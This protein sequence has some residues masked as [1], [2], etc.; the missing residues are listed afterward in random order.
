MGVNSPTK[1][2]FVGKGLMLKSIQSFDLGK[3]MDVDDNALAFRFI[4]KGNKNLGE[5][6][7][8]MAFHLKHL[9]YS[10][11]FIVTVIFYG[12]CCPNC[13]HSSLQMKK[14]AFLKKSNRTFC[15]FKSLQLKD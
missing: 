15:C 2:K 8:D 12:T 9:P 14:E 1:A 11:G 6:L 10:G 3:Q 13:K 4:G 7:S 5:I